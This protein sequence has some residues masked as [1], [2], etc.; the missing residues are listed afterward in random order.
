MELK[1][2]EITCDLIERLIGYP[3]KPIKIRQAPSTVRFS[4]QRILLVFRILNPELQNL[5]SNV[6][7]IACPSIAIPQC[8]VKVVCS[9]IMKVYLRGDSMFFKISWAAD[10]SRSGTVWFRSGMVPSCHINYQTFGENKFLVYLKYNL[11][12]I[13]M[14]VYSVVILFNSDSL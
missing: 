7:D 4:L 1:R 12:K 6:N 14:Q 11:H 9:N 2:R 10:P 3:L 13:P 8:V 5:F